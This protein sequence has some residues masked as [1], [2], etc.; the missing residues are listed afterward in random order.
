MVQLF[1]KLLTPTFDLC[2]LSLPESDDAYIFIPGG[3]GA[4]KT[5][6]KNLI[7]VA[8]LTKKGFIFKENILTDDGEQSNLCSSVSAVNVKV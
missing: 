7:H 4:S 6:V 5:G 1:G 8:I 3:G 2:W